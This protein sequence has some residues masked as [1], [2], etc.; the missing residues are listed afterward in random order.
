MQPMISVLVSAAFLAQPVPSRAAEVEL[1]I[2]RV[3][4][5]KG[6]LHVCVTGNP[7]HFPDCSSDPAAIKR[8]VAAAT[9]VLGLG[10]IA[11]GRYAVTVFHDENGNRKLDTVLG[12]PRE[13]FGFS[14]N[15]RIRFGAP[16][17]SQVDIE[18]RPGLARHTVRLQY[19]L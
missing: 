15:P 11:P 8:T 16:R 1:Q 6:V 5:G 4:N 10:R 3:R 17:Y 9:R 13:G 18:L 2:E 19:M 7:R 14:R 12:I